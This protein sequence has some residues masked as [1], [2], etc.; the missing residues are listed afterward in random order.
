MIYDINLSYEENLAQPPVID[1]PVEFSG[2]PKFRLMGREVWAPIGI[3]AGILPN[4]DYI[5]AAVE[6]GAPIL[7]YKTVRTE[8]RECHPFPNCLFLAPDTVV[9]PGFPAVAS[10]KTTGDTMTNSFGMPSVHPNVW[11]YDVNK[12]QSYVDEKPGRMMIV[13][14]VGTPNASAPN[15]RKHLADDY[16]LCA[17]LAVEAGA[18]AIELNLSCPNVGKEGLGSI[19][20]DSELTSEIIRTVRK[21]IGS[22]IPLLIK[23]GYYE[24]ESKMK[25]VAA[26]ALKAGVS[27]FVGINTIS[28][29]VVDKDGNQALPGAGRLSSGVCGAGIAPYAERWLESMLKLRH[30]MK[31]DFAIGSSGGI[32]THEKFGERL[33]RGA[34]FALSTTGAMLRPEIFG[35]FFKAAGQRNS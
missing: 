11:M 3:A 4:S 23:V 19:Y 14:V 17:E 1:K 30:E 28:M 32:M 35:D 16:A 31:A 10:R 7:T 34:D 27:G 26:A 22:E 18:K 20:Q 5:K 13:S 21:D 25:S 9:K 2:K 33:E 29:N 15:Q 6:A 24:D 8:E 12:A